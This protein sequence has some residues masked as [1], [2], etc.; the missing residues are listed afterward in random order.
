[1]KD[2]E[3]A[4]L[5]AI[6]VIIWQLVTSGAVPAEPLAAELERYAGFAGNAAASLRTLAHVARAAALPSLV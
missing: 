6:E 5:G 1:M 4:A 3:K 2:T